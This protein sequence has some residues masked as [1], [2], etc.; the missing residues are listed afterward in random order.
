LFSSKLYIVDIYVG[1]TIVSSVTLKAVSRK[2]A[3]RATEAM[4]K[5]RV[6][7]YLARPQDYLRPR[8]PR[9]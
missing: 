1:K 9:R 7:G 5:L 8:I 4:V 6:S 2:A 3:I